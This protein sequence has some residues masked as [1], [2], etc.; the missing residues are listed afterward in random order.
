MKIWFV[1]AAVATGAAFASPA[2]A[3]MTLKSQDG[4]M[5]CAAQLL[6]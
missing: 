3:D 6:A 5:E 2:Y 1:V 4:T